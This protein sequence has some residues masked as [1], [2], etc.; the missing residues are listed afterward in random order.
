MSGRKSI[1][2]LVSLVSPRRFCGL[3]DRFDAVDTDEIDS[4]LD[5]N[6]AMGGDWG[7]SNA[8]LDPSRCSCGRDEEGRG[9]L[10]YRLLV[11]A[12]TD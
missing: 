5:V 10:S 12:S 11:T 4:A 9:V 2:T 6:V 3:R 8:S 7:G 1:G